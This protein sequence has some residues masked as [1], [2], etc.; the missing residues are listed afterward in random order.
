MRSG[1]IL[2]FVGEMGEEALRCEKIGGTQ[3]TN[4]KWREGQDEVYRT[5]NV[6]ILEYCGASLLFC[7]TYRFFSIRVETFSEAKS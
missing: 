3:T 2:V 6:F 5:D 1:E 4:C 7:D